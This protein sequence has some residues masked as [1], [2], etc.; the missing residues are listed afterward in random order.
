MEN[1]TCKEQVLEF[2]INAQVQPSLKDILLEMLPLANCFY[3]I[4]N[5]IEEA[6]RSESGQVLQALSAALRKLVNDYFDSISQLESMHNKHQLN[7][8]KLLYFLR[9]VIHTMETIAMTIRELKAYNTRGGNVL[10]RLHDSIGLLSGDKRAQEILIYLTQMA[11]EP[12][13]EILKLWI[14]KGIIIDPQ[15]EFLIEENKQNYNPELDQDIFSAHWEKQYVIRNDKIPRF[16][17]K[18]ADM[19]L[20]TGKYLNVIRECGKIVPQ[21]EASN[22]KIFAYK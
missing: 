4:Q 10:T 9:P 21:K 20:R 5:F 22:F 19:I 3:Q 7:L 18:Q 11:A 14:Y 13:M 16:L 2:E 6:Q 15:Q 17:E 12:Y 1:A 8:Q